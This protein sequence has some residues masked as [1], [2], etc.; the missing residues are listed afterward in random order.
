[1]T[2]VKYDWSFFLGSFPCLI[3]LF[4]ICSKYIPN[5]WREL[6]HALISI[7]CRVRTLFVPILLDQLRCCLRPNPI[8]SL[9]TNP[10]GML[11]KTVIAPLTRIILHRN[12]QPVEICK[13]KKEQRNRVNW[14][15]NHFHALFIAYVP[16]QNEWAASFLLKPCQWSI[17]VFHSFDELISF[18]FGNINVSVIPSYS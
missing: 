16:I 13:K 17:H 7:D 18:P 10:L 5:I 12:R 2:F 3:A 11:A 9:D 15:F 14:N 4:W 6:C 1:M 8:V